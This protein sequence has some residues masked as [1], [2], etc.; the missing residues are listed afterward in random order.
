[1]KTIEPDTVREQVRVRYGDIAKSI[2]EC[3]GRMGAIRCGSDKNY[4][5]Q[6]GY[7]AGEVRSVP[8]SSNLGLGCGNPTA[9]AFIRPGETVLDLGSGAGF[10]CFLAARQLDGTGRV[11]GV[12]MT[13]P[14]VAKARDNARKGNYATGCSKQEAGLPLRTWW[15]PNRCPNAFAHKSMP[16]EDVSAGPLWSMISKTC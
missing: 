4:D 13:P 8:K 2:R 14:M 10:D 12:D 15:Q 1:M 11:I 6:L 3:C 5:Q 16:S 7:S 9:I